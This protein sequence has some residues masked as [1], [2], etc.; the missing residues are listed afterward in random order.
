MGFG[1]IQTTAAD[2]KVSNV[3]KKIAVATF[4]PVEEAITLFCI[5]SKTPHLL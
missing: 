5:I 1:E 3:I 4:S 2:L